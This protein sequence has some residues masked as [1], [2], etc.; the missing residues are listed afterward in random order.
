MIFFYYTIINKNKNLPIKITSFNLIHYGSIKK[1]TD[2]I[3]L[4][5]AFEFNR[6]GYMIAES[7]KIRYEIIFNHILKF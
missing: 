7:S 4:I 1:Y 3:K 6:Y 5:V 2:V